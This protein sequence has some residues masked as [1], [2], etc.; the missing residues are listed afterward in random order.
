MVNARAMFRVTVGAGAKARA[1][2]SVRHG[3]GEG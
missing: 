2:G 1:S 3:L